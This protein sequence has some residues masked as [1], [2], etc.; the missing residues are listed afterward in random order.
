MLARRSVLGGVLSTAACGVVSRRDRRRADRARRRGFES[1]AVQSGPD[2]VH[3][4]VHA[5]PSF[6]QHERPLVLVHGFG[7]TALFQWE[8]QLELFAE[9]R[10]VVVPDLLWFGASSSDDDDPS[11]RHHVRALESLFDELG[12][13]VVDLVGVSYGGF[14]SLELARAMP[15]RIGS[16]VMVDSPGAAWSVQRHEAMLASF[17]ATSAADLFVPET[18]DDVRVLLDLAISEPPAVPAFAARQ[19]IE[20]YYEPNRAQL[21]RL[22]DHLED[23]MEA[24]LAQP[25]PIPSRSLV[26]WGEHDP[27]FGVDVAPE[28]AARLSAPV[29]VLPGARHLS[30]VDAPTAFNRAVLDFLVL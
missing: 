2:R 29:V 14:V 11:L 16:I 5:G 21:R 8:H 22:L 28:L 13:E 25:M 18:V 15:E 30:N 20:A 27:V 19:A 17:G 24:L 9:F 1:V 26:V 3:A 10:R 12:A 7:G 6:A 4:R 23:E